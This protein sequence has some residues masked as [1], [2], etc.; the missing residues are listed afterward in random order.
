MSETAID[1]NQFFFGYGNKKVL[2]DVGLAVPAGQYVAMIG[3]NG[4]GKSTLLK[5]INRIVKG[6]EGSIRLFGKELAAYSQKELGRL[7]GYVPQYHEQSFAYTVF[8][9]VLM[10]RYPYFDAL[11]PPSEEDEKKVHEMLALIGLGDFKDRRVHQISGGERQKVYIAAALAQE[12]RVLLLDEPTAHLDPRYHAEIQQLISKVSRNLGLTVLHVTHDLNH[13]FSWSQKVI[14]LKNGRVLMQGTPQEVL[15]PK[16]L[17]SI[18][19]TRFIFIP[20]PQTR[21][22]IIVPEMS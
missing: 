9:F 19:D 3:P 15:T 7:I 13:I 11:R 12:P 18:F 20:H 8:E 16:N 10:A 21:Q 2:F 5:S 17:E 14:A 4:V 1:I 6:Q 22:P